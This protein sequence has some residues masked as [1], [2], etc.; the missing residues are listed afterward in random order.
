MT[1][2]PG[3]KWETSLWAIPKQDIPAPT[4]TIVVDPSGSGLDPDS[5]VSLHPYPD[6]IRIHN[7]YPDPGGKNDTQKQ[8]KINKF[9]F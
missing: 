9:H 4:Q 3:S 2:F 7:P 6:G 1:Y 8:K 5:M